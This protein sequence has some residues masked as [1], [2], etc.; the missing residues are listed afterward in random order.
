M[1]GY[2]KGQYTLTGSKVIFWQ[3]HVSV[4]DMVGFSKNY[5]KIVDQLDMQ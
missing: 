3:I 1:Y 5:L 4:S 2:D